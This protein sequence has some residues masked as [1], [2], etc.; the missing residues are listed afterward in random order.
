MPELGGDTPLETC[1]AEAQQAGFCG[2]ELGGKFPRA[3]SELSPILARH[4]L[5]LASG[6]FSGLLRENNSVKEEMQR[7]REQLE[8]FAAL[9]ATELF[10]ADTSGSVQAKINSPLSTRPQMPEHEFPAYG[11]KLTALAA[12][13]QSEYGIAM[14]YHHHMGTLIENDRDID[15]LFMH[16]GEEV[17]LLADSGHIAFAGGN[18]AALIRRHAKRLRY[19]HCKDLRE[20]PLAQAR[21][22]DW[23]FM[24]AVLAGVFTVP[25]DGALDFMQFISAAADAEYGGWMVVEAEQDPAQANP[26]E[27]SRSGLRHIRD[28]CERAGLHIAPPQNGV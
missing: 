13:M 26:L 6:W 23:S 19:V 12:Q 9:G 22:E 25:G 20:S 4:K 14:A 3:A 18:P 28:C 15:L 10:Y 27:Y 16:T 2:I 1:L 21:S 5:R 11:E 24:R 7:M 17:G 8:C